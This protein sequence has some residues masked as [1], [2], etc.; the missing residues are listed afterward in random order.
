MLAARARGNQEI[1]ATESQH[2]VGRSGICLKMKKMLGKE[3]EE[4]ERGRKQGKGSGVCNLELKV[5][6]L[7]AREEWLMTDITAW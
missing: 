5:D 6:T 3:S 7:T 4:N 2:V 1:K